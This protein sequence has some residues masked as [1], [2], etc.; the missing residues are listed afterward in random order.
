M[1]GTLLSGGALLRISFP[2]SNDLARL[3]T[4]LAEHP[5]RYWEL[6]LESEVSGVGYH[7]TF[8]VP[9]YS[10]AGSRRLKWKKKSRAA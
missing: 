2:L 8:L 7:A 9:I 6:T 1:A 5:P 10:A 3:G 4:C